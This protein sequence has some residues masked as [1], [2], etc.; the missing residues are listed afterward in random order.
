MSSG[1]DGVI[2]KVFGGLGNQM[3]QYAAGR[4]LAT[5]LRQP[6][7]I[8]TRSSHREGNAHN[9]FELTRVFAMEPDH[10]T[11]NS[12]RRQ[13]GWRSPRL[14]QRLL[15]R[16]KAKRLYGRYVPEP[17]YH[18]WP[19]FEVLEGPCFLDGYWQ[20][21][22]YFAASAKALRSEFAFRLPLEHAN[23][24]IA[25]QIAAAP[26]PVSIHV[27]RGDY[28]S[29]SRTASHHGVLGL[30]YYRTALD[31]VVD[32]LAR[33]QFFVFSDDIAWARANL[34]VP[35]DAVFVGHNTT[36]DSHFDMH[37]MSRCRHHVIANS[38]FSW[39][40][41]WLNADPDKI[42]IAPSRWFLAPFDTTT[43]TP[44]SWTRI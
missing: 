41:A 7:Q 23:A 4:A 2:A 10:A 18:F 42:V 13:L 21:F 35:G 40:A 43:L 15:R 33:P 1:P 28:V 5:R 20:S 16:S 32:R 30:D 17:H 27:R 44:P 31:R 37:L 11:D 26:H 12:V 6:L 14:V 3:F 8:D 39:W 24:R 22:L 29:S 19:G 38:S 36:L 25:E 34:P 9:G